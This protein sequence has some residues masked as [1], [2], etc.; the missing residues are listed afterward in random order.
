MP[1]LVVLIKAVDEDVMAEACRTA[2]HA[3]VHEAVNPSS[4]R[5]PRKSR[6][7]QSTSPSSTEA[8]GVSRTRSPSCGGAASQAAMERRPRLV[9]SGSPDHRTFTGV[10]LRPLKYVR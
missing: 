8:S 3:D 6:E 4:V 2:E 9:S 5:T 1:A 7:S 10:A